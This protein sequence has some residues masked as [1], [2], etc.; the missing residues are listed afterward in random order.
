MSNQTL[1]ELENYTVNKIGIF[2]GEN[3]HNHNTVSV[4]SLENPDMIILYN[5]EKQLKIF[6]ELECDEVTWFSVVSGKWTD[7]VGHSIDRIIQIGDEDVSY[8]EDGEDDDE[9]EYRYYHSITTYT[10]QSKDKT[11]LTFEFH[12][13]SYGY[14][15]SDIKVTLI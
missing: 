9:E 15:N 4:D 7:L 3:P 13:Q 12:S 2:Y 11:L 1:I 5:D 6:T 8:A 14:Y 10:I